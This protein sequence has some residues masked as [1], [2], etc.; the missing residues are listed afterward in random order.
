MHYA[1]VVSYFKKIQKHLVGDL[2]GSKNH[3]IVFGL[4]WG[5]TL[6]FGAGIPRGTTTS[7]SIQ[8]NRLES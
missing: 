7:S 5:I 4:V 8:E 3:K 2:L 6:F 1:V